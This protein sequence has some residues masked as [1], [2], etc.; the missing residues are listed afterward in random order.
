MA[1]AMSVMQDGDNTGPEYKTQR[2]H[3]EKKMHAN[4]D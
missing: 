2:S 3:V 1:K 4:F